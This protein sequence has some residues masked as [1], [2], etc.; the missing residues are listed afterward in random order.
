MSTAAMIGRI[1]GASPRFKA[2]IAGVFYL[3]T[4][5]GGSAALFFHGQ[6]YSIAD[7]LAGASFVVVTLLLYDLFKSVNH[8][9]SLLAAV[10]SL[11]GSGFGRLGWQPQG[12]NIEMVFFGFYSLLI[13]YL[14]FRS[15]LLPRTL[16]AVMALA[17]LAWLT[18][19]SPPLANYLDPY[20]RAAGGVAQLSLCLWLLVMGVNEKKTSA[21]RTD[22]APR[23]RRTE[24]EQ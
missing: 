5:V 2:R 19:L 23:P 11:M 12:V 1:E 22:S 21:V 15:T 7:V 18:F 6:A 4:I 17:G 10:L 14:I 24:Y 8:D 9:L 16:G 3:I 13:G 20:N